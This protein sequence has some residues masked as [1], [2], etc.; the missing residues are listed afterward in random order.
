MQKCFIYAIISIV[1]AYMEV[2]GHLGCSSLHV[3]VLRGGKRHQFL[4]F[5]FPIIVSV[6]L[7]FLKWRSIELI[8]LLREI[9]VKLLKAEILVAGF[10]LERRNPLFYWWFLG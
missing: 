8:Q 4:P 10:G 1:I 5:F 3:L 2:A 9:S 6:M 7:L